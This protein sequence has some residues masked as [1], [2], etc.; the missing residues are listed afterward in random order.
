M[1]DPT[2]Q[3]TAAGGIFLDNGLV[4]GGGGVFNGVFSA[5]AGKFT[6]D[7]QGNTIQTGTLRTAGIN[8]N[9][10][11][12]NNRVTN[13]APAQAPTDAV[14]RGFVQAQVTALSIALS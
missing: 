3:L 9:L 11:L 7:S 6:V 10:D 1:L 8:G 12:L 2:I 5:A 13:L 4:A 14:S